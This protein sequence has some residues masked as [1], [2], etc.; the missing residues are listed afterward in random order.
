L[1]EIAEKNGRIPAFSG[2]IRIFRGIRRKI[3]GFFVRKMEEKKNRNFAGKCGK[4]RE[5]AEKCG[6]ISEK[7]GKMRRKYSENTEI[8]GKIRSFWRFY[9]FVKNRR[10][11]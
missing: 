3:R 2:T 10:N 7:C 5:N 6:K 1:G 9:G 8:Y 11:F 4:M